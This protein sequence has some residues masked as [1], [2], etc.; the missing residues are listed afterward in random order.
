MQPSGL[1]IRLMFADDINLL[2][3]ANINGSGESSPVASV[4]GS[5]VKLE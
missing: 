3:T 2:G 4:M 5:F 1:E